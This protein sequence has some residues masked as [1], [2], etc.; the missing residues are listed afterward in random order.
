LDLSP[1]SVFAGLFLRCVAQ[2][3]PALLTS[4]VAGYLLVPDALTGAYIVLPFGGNCWYSTMLKNEVNTPAWV[5]G[6]LFFN[7][8]VF[9]PVLDALRDK[10]AG[11][12]LRWQLLFVSWLMTL[13]RAVDAIGMRVLLLDRI[14]AQVFLRAQTPAFIAGVLLASI[15]I[16]RSSISQQ[17]S[18]L[19]FFTQ[20]SSAAVVISCCC[21]IPIPLDVGPEPVTGVDFAVAWIASGAMIPFW[22][23]MIWGLAQS[24]RLNRMLSN[25]Y[26]LHVMKCV[27][28][29]RYTALMVQQLAWIVSEKLNG[30]FNNDEESQYSVYAVEWIIFS[31]MFPVLTL[32][33]H[34]L[35]AIPF[36]RLIRGVVCAE[37]SEGLNQANEVVLDES[38]ERSRTERLQ[39]Y[40]FS[41]ILV[42]ILFVVCQLS[43]GTWVTLLDITGLPEFANA[44][45]G[46]SWLLLIPAPALIQGLLGLVLFPAVAQPQVPTLAEQLACVQEDKAKERLSPQ[47]FRIHFRIVTRG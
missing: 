36:S 19:Q 23:A 46:I 29:C 37:S 27:S 4:C 40:Y 38:I 14:I 7:C 31:V 39:M 28:S 45:G 33:I 13:W 10:E 3:W 44:L 24:E 6:A 42:V 12:T 11:I 22:V 41:M 15:Y 16:D 9:L 8:V 32:V 34:Y 18:I 26:I 17:R 1:K 20:A 5:A 25:K 2:I 35:I 47:E 43:A 21:L 30:Y